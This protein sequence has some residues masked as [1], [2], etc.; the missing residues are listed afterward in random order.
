MALNSLL[1]ADVPLSTYT[2]TDSLSDLWSTYEVNKA[3]TER[4]NLTNTT[5]LWIIGVNSL[6]GRRWDYLQDY[7]LFFG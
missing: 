2:L 6:K 1:R 5:H 4:M 3:A 7:H